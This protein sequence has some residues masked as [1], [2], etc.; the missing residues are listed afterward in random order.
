VVNLLEVVPYVYTY[1]IDH[2]KKILIEGGIVV[3]SDSIKLVSEI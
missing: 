2:Y 1:I 3:K